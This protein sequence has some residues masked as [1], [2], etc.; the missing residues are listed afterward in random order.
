MA[1]KMVLAKGKKQRKNKK[2]NYMDI[3]ND[4]TLTCMC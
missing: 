2:L 3:I 4:D 1:D